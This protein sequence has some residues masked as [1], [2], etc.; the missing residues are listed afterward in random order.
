M[1]FDL[2]ILQKQATAE[3]VE[4]LMKN[5]KWPWSTNV[6]NMYKQAIAENNIIKTQ[7]GASL[8]NAQTVYNQAA[9]IELLSWNSKEGSFLLNGAIIGHTPDMPENINNLVR[10]G[11]NS[12]TGDISMQKIQYTGY[13]GIY[14]NMNSTVTPVKN[15][16]LP[17]AVNGFKF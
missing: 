4:E 1:R 17:T 3:E 11:K 8:E 14:G 9:I 2:D 13:N 6:Q 5:G 12:S 15:S 7:P 16:D 10:C